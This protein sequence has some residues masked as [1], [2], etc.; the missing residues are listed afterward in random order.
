MERDISYL[1]LF[2]GLAL[3]ALAL[4]KG[5]SRRERRLRLLEHRVR[6]LEGIATDPELE[7]P[8]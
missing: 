8:R 4:T 1:L 5:T 6:T 2:T 3:V 7:A